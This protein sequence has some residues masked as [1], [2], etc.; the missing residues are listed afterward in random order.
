MWRGALSLRSMA[1]QLVF[2]VAAVLAALP[3]VHSLAKAVLLL[4]VGALAF[5]IWVFEP[6]LEKRD[7]RELSA[8]A[9]ARVVCGPEVAE[10][11]FVAQ[12]RGR[13][14]GCVLVEKPVVQRR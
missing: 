14:V 7:A 9:V 6:V 12:A 5:R 2:L 13:V 4:I 11:L 8:S 10:Q 1:L 3:L